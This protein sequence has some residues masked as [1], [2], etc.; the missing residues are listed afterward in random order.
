[1]KVSLCSL[2]YCCMSCSIRHTVLTA[3]PSLLTIPINFLF[4]FY[5]RLYWYG[6][7]SSGQKWNF[8][9]KGKKHY[10]TRLHARRPYIYIIYILYIY[11][12]Y[13][14]I[15]I[16]IYIYIYILHNEILTGWHFS[17]LSKTFITL[18]LFGRRKWKSK[19]SIFRSKSTVTIK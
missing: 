9:N 10:Y 13:I 3:S 6:M 4:L 16:N 14:Y 1:M 7:Q 8:F 5:W 17:I 11:I 12:Y 2:S 18:T 19:K 15:Y